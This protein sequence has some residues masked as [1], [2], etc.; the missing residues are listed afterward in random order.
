MS[1]YKVTASNLYSV[2]QDIDDIEIKI[3]PTQFKIEL[4]RSGGHGLNGSSIT[5]SRIN[6]L[7]ELILTVVDGTGAVSELNS[8]AVD[9][10]LKQ[11]SND[12]ELLRLADDTVFRYQNQVMLA[13]TN[14]GDLNVKGDVNSNHTFNAV[15]TYPAVDTPMWISNDSRIFE[16]TTNSLMFQNGGIV[17]MEI[18][19]TGDLNISGSINSNDNTL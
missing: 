16:T 1:E 5:A 7:G 10:E 3:E 11:I 8:G 17:N 4:G 13:M 12:W 15:G 9:Y 14:S 6:S 2:T 18:T 19:L